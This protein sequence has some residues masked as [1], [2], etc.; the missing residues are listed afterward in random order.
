ME[1]GSVHEILVLITYAQKLPLNADVS[2]WA[3]D[4]F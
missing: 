3:R 1:Y 2:S 4:I